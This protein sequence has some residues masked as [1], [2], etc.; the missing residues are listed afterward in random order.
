[1]RYIRSIVPVALA[2]V[3]A[4]VSVARGQD[5]SGSDK[6]VSKEDYQ[7]LKAEHERLKQEMEALKS[8]MQA[9]LAKGTNQETAKV[10]AQVEDLQKKAASRQA[11]TDQTLDEFDKE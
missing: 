7:K 11:E 3:V 4:T 6:F 2:L 1:M 9:V 5:Q 8:Q 10:K